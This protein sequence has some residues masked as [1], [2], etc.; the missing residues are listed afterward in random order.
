M[1]AGSPEVRTIL[2]VVTLG[3]PVQRKWAGGAGYMVLYST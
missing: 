3:V 1:P 2:R